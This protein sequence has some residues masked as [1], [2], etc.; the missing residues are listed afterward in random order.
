MQYGAYCEI[1]KAREDTA[2]LNLVG[3]RNLEGLGALGRL[4]LEGLLLF[5][6]PNSILY[7]IILLLGGR[8]RG[9]SPSSSIS[10]SIIRVSVILV[11]ASFFPY[12]LTINCYCVYD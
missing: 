1:R 8:W 4:G 5:V 7:W 10:S 9:F 11:F 6:Y 12:S 2:R 3:E